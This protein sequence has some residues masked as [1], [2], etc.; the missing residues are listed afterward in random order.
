MKGLYLQHV[1][2]ETPRAIL[3]WA[4]ERGHELRGIHLFAGDPL[5]REFPE[6]V[7]VMGGPMSVHDEDR[8][9]W[10]PEEKGYLREALAAGSRIL[11][12]CLGAQLLA[13]ILG[14]EVVKNRHKEIGWFPVHLTDE[15]LKHSLFEG[16]PREFPAFHWHGETF[17]LPEGAMHVA[18]SEACRNQAFLYRDQA[19]ALQ[20]HLEM[21]PEGA[22]DL[23]RH[24]AEDLVPGPYVQSPEEI[25]GR[26]SLYRTTREILFTL[27][28][29]FVDL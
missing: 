13:E 21:T 11:G 4:D 16:L 28:D 29:R 6:L 12:I 23:L 9:P 18:Y 19:L 2:F 7:V 15:A 24:S 22:E 8:Y 17:G 3:D 26:D 20:F 10:L 25:R 27:L 1:P 14:A 5:P